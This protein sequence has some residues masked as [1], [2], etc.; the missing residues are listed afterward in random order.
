MSGTRKTLYGIVAV[1]ALA[2]LALCTMNVGGG[3]IAQKASE[4]VKS[5]YNLTLSI[6]D[7]S[8]N[9]VRGYTMSGIG[10]SQGSQSLMTADSLFVD[11]ALMKLILGH[12]GVDW[13]E[14]KN[15]VTSPAKAM[16]LAE[17]F[18]KKKLPPLPATIPAGI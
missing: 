18:T 6:K 16:R 13:I 14:A 10:I 2:I 12:I 3:F 7:T 5:S 9:P 15:L 1:L 4:F 17:I 11:P 8:G